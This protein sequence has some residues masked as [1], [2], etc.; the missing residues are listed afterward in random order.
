MELSAESEALVFRGSFTT[1]VH[2]STRDISAR[3]AA[4]R[5][6]VPENYSITGL[7]YRSIFTEQFVCTR[8]TTLVSARPK[9]PSTRAK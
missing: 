8:Y 2:I 4:F 3:D 9:S 6:S 1:G 5:D 7:D